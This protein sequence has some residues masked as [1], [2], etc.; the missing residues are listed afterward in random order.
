MCIVYVDP[1][2]PILTILTTCTL[3]DMEARTH[4]IVVEALLRSYAKIAGSANGAWRSG[5]FPRAVFRLPARYQC[6]LL[7][8]AIK[9]KA[10]GKIKRGSYDH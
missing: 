3:E 6:R 7:E 2:V 9:P 4:I 10:K 1:S 5:D 8:R